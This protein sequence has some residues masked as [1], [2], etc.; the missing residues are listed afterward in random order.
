LDDNTSDTNVSNVM[1]EA[2][3][4]EGWVVCRIFKKKNLNKTLDRPFSSSPITEDTR[5]QTL[6]SCNEGSLDQILHYMG[7]TCKEENEADNS[8]RYL[9]PINTAINHVHHD[10]FMKLP[11]LESP[12]S[13]SSQNC[14]QPIITDNEA[15]ITNQVSYPL[16]SGLDNWSALD[17]LVASQ[18]NGQNETSRQLDCFPVEPTMTY[19]TPTDLHRDLQLPT[20]RSSFSLLSNRSYHG[21]QDYNSEIDLWNF[22]IRSSSDPLCH[23]SNTSV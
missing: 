17:R 22:T 9:R 16:D 1:G 11:S 19:S 3:Q 5:S 2:G 14:F 4:E 13:V 8:A 10:R 23:L 21:T 7:R 18:L 15:S 12:N 20:L 6:N